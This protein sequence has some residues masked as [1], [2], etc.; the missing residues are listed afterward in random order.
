VLKQFIHFA[1]HGTGTAIHAFEFSRELTI[2]LALFRAAGNVSSQLQNDLNVCGVQC[3]DGHDAR[4]PGNPIIALMAM[5]F[6][7]Q[8]LH[9]HNSSRHTAGTDAVDTDKHQLKLKYSQL[10]MLLEIAPKHLNVALYDMPAVLSSAPLLRN[11]CSELTE[12]H[13]SLLDHISAFCSAKSAECCATDVAAARSQ[14]HHQILFPES[15]AQH[16]AMLA[17]QQIPTSIEYY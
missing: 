9:R 2:A 12:A 16:S 1:Q 8:F 17:E 14:P 5:N 11:L 6:I 7:S 3:G 15:W 4:L 10:N 13:T